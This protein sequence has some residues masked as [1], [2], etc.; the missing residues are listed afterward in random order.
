VTG[1]PTTVFIARDG[2]VVRRWTGT[3]TE[4]QLMT[5]VEELAR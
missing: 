3:L 1:L 5:F 2:T 4:Q